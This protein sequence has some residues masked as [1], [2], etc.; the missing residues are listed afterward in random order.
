M[1]GAEIYLQL[2]ICEWCSRPERSN[3]LVLSETP[4]T[5]IYGLMV[6]VLMDSAHGTY[7]SPLWSPLQGVERLFGRCIILQTT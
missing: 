6:D 4:W 2:F 3:M 5:E 1:N 7:P